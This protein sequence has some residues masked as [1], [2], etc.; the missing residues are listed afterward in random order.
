VEYCALVM[1]LKGVQRALDSGLTKIK[2]TASASRTHSMKNMNRTPEE[3]VRDFAEC[4][5]FALS[6]GME[7]SGAVSTAFGCPF[8]PGASGNVATEDLVYMFEQDGI[9][10]GLDRKKVMAVAA[11]ACTWLEREPD[12]CQIKVKKCQEAL[13]SNCKNFEHYL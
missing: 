12:S 4:A 11:D 6:R 3:V 13:V 2:L 7:V 9:A 8:A 5:S 1:N 10:T